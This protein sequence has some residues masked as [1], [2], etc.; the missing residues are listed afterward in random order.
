MVYN[1]MCQKCLKI[2]AP[3][4]SKLVFGH[5]AR[6]NEIKLKKTNKYKIRN[7]IC[8]SRARYYK[9][10]MVTTFDPKYMISF[11]SSICR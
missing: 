11:I 2:Y 8:I 1:A 10:Q 4:I 6:Q 3:P 5:L 9:L 7:D